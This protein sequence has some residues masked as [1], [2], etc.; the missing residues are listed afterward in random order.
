[1]AFKCD[2]KTLYIL[3]LNSKLYYTNIF[4]ECDTQSV[5][6]SSPVSLDGHQQMFGA[7][8]YSNSLPHTQMSLICA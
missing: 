1:M 8:P 6:R 3:F 4:L 7:W 2:F 5:L